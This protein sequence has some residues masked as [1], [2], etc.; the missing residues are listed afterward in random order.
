[1]VWLLLACLGESGPAGDVDSGSAGADSGETGD[2]AADT[3]DS[4]GADDSGDTG[5][6]DDTVHV[7]VTR[8]DGPSQA[9]DCG[10]DQPGHFDASFDDALGNTAG[11]LSCAGELGSF[12]LQWTNGHAGSWATPDDGVSF[13]WTGS[14]AVPWRYDSDGLS[15]WSVAFAEYDRTDTQTLALQGSAAAVWA[16][17]TVDAT[18]EA[19]LDCTNCP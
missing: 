7:E 3:G 19:R 16:L 1:M 5:A 14:D 10:Q 4:G 8:G 13:T 11:H 17:L 9:L 2:S 6:A 12:L 18:F 15:S